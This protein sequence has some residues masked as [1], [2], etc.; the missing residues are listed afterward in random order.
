MC[1]V[2]ALESPHGNV[3]PLIRLRGTA[4]SLQ[5]EGPEVLR[6]HTLMPRSMHSNSGLSRTIRNCTGT[7]SIPIQQVLCMVM[8][9]R[10][11]YSSMQSLV[12]EQSKHHLTK[13]CFGVLTDNSRPALRDDFSDGIVRNVSSQCNNTIVV[14]HN[15]GVRLVDQ[16][17]ENPNVTAVIFAHLPGQDSG[18]ALTEILYGDVSPSGKLPY[19]VARNESDYGPVLSPV[20]DVGPNGEYT[21][22]PQDDFDEGVYIDYRAFDAQGIE[23]RYE[24]GFGL[25]YTTFEYSDLSAGVVNSGSNLSAYP[26][27]DVLPGGQADLWDVIATASA[28]VTNTGGVAAQEVAQLYLGIPVEGQPM[29]Q[30]RGFEK[31]MIQP[32]ESAT[33]EFELRRR[34]MSVW[35][36]QAQRWR[37]ALG[38]EYQFYVGSSSRDLPLTTTLML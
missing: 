26:T 17:I 37:L 13:L 25:T 36:V 32:G 4:P 15:A 28:T 29:R 38:A 8:L 35:D 22:F 30:L 27:E 3:V 24:F 23:P 7:S 9:M 5:E 11:S 18:T 2:L 16:W 12:K 14:I 31:V 34:D 19:T 10:H 20:A 33:V 1:A 21:F 6:L